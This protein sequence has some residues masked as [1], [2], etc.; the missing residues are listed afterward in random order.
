MRYTTTTTD[1]LW[2]DKA[3]DSLIALYEHTAPL[4]DVQPR[5]SQRSIKAYL[6]TFQSL[7]AVIVESGAWIE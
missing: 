1:Q 5:K 4:C 2:E 6:L 7:L 3:Q